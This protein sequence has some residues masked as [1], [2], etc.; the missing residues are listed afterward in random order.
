MAVEEENFGAPRK[1]ALTSAQ[2]LEFCKL[3]RDN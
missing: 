3:A 1:L 2:R